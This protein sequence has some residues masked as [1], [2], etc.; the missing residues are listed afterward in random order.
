MQACFLIVQYVYNVSLCPF[1]AGGDFYQIR[2]RILPVSVRKRGLVWPKRRLFVDG[3]R[4]IT[5]LKTQSVSSLNLRGKQ[6][7]GWLVHAE[8]ENNVQCE[9][10]KKDRQYGRFR[11]NSE[12]WGY[13]SL[14]LVAVFFDLNHVQKQEAEWSKRNKAIYFRFS[15]QYPKSCNLSKSDKGLKNRDL[16]GIIPR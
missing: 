14:N 15:N 1:S 4:A 3:L 11:H 16:D 6:I 8:T 5:D 10:I 12:I 7:K 13:R 2:R 9:T